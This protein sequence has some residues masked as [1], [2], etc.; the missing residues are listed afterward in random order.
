MRIVAIDIGTFTCR[1][2]TGEVEGHDPITPVCSGRKILW[3]DKGVDHTKQLKPEAMTR[4]I[5]TIREWKN[6]IDEHDVQASIVVATST[7]REAGNRKEFLRRAE[8]EAAV[9]VRREAALLEKPTEI[10]G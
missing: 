2:L 7:V 1:L 10:V 8:Q 3:L 9:K 4:L 6:V 5:K